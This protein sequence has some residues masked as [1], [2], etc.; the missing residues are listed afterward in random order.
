[1]INHVGKM[2]V[3]AMGLCMIVL[4]ATRKEEMVDIIIVTHLKIL[5]FTPFPKIFPYY[6]KAIFK[7][8]TC[9]NPHLGIFFID[10]WWLSVKMYLNISSHWLPLIMCILYGPWLWRCLFCWIHCWRVWKI[11]Y[12]LIKQLLTFN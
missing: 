9:L 1:M 2:C 5:C 7:Y 11:P 10:L 3:A 12:Y 8:W 4:I 6:K